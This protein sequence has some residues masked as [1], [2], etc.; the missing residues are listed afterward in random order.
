MSH[1]NRLNRELELATDKQLRAELLARK[2]CYLARLGLYDE[3]SQLV[4]HL[5][6]AYGDWSSG[7]THVWIMIAEALIHWYSNFS[8]VALDRVIRAQVLSTAMRYDTVIAISSA[9][10][11]HI[12][13]ELSNFAGM[14]A[15]LEL[16][17]KFT[18]KENADAN[19]RIANILCSAFASCGDRE[20]LQ[21][22][23]MKG[24]EF[25]LADGDQVS[26]EALQY[27]KAIFTVNWTRA[28]QFR[29]V[30]TEGVVRSA[31][32]EFESSKNFQKITGNNTFMNY[33]PMCE[34]RLFIAEKKYEEAI[35]CFEL[36]KG[37][38]NFA[39]YNYSDYLIDLEI[40]Y[41]YFKLGAHE[42]AVQSMA[43]VEYEALVNLDIHERFVAASMLHEMCIGDS[44]FGD[45]GQIGKKRLELQSAYTTSREELKTGLGRLPVE[46]LLG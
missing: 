3:A 27:N 10:K 22:W 24:R 1:L 39:S 6:S 9:W 36:T 2:V 41:C 8:P 43:T 7:R 25:A 38:S 19:V 31:R 33:F 45:A 30:L 28:E 34:A 26:I 16:A 23:F 4:A 12:E 35:G 11:A 42:K 40:S 37:Q 13:F 32:R 46:K 21:V 20:G 17:I 44:S 18:T 14:F 5:R 15:S 29:E